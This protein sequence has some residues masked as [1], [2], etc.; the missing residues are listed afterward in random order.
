M[1]ISSGGHVRGPSASAA[2]PTYSFTQDGSSG[3]YRPGGVSNTIRFA[4]AA[5]DRVQI[6]N[7][8]TTFMHGLLFARTT[9]GNVNYVIQAND[10]II[11]YTSLT[12]PRIATLPTAVGVTGQAYVIKD[13][14]GAAAT[15]AITVATTSG[16]LIDGVTTKSINT[17]YGSLIVY[18]TGS[19]WVS[20]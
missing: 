4:T 20:I 6:N 16:Q 11:A 1:N 5:N 7:T 2:A 9:I 13:E 10:Y 3:M 14:A 17:N 19:A 8:G 12:A 15:H 18:S